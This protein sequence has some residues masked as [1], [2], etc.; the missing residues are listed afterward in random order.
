MNKKRN[1]INH[2]ADSLAT[3]LNVPM[4]GKLAAPVLHSLCILYCVVSVNIF[5]TYKMLNDI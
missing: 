5:I 2:T 3:L 1:G 4:G